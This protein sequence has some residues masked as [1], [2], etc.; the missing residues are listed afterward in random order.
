VEISGSDQIFILGSPRSGTS[1]LLHAL[2]EVFSLQGREEGHLFPVFT[3]ILHT[4]HEYSTRFKR[5]PDLLSSCLDT[6]H[7]R[8]H[9]LEYIRGIYKSVH[10]TG[11]FIDKTP[12]AESIVA[13]RLIKETFPKSR[14]LMVR[15]NGIDYSCSFSKKFCVSIHAAA[16]SWATCMRA[17]EVA[18]RNCGDFLEI[19][20]SELLLDP[21]SASCK[22]ARYLGRPEQRGSLAT[23][24]SQTRVETSA[25]GGVNFRKAPS[26]LSDVCWTELEK[27]QFRET[28]GPLMLK[29]GYDF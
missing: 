15:R 7:F 8:R 17:L 6:D 14:I 13:A 27:I 2:K 22:I 12:G 23:V 19:D 21:E 10:G 9:I 5:S 24:L 18:R 11:G 28:C 20:H 1:A 16:Q 26:R 4:F 25:P 29:F 3:S